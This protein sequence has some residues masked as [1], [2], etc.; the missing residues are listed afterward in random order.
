MTA[1]RD[2]LKAWR[3]A[4]LGM[5]IHWGLYSI[6]AGVWNDDLGADAGIDQA[7]DYAAAGCDYAEHIQ[8][9]RKIPMAEYAR[10]AGRFD[11]VEFDAAEWIRIAEQAGMR[12]IVFTAKHQD[13]FAMYRSHVDPF[14][15]VE[16]TPF[17]RDPLAELAAAVRDRGLG[18]GIYYSHAR[19]HHH[20][21]ANW[22]RYG[23]TWDFPPGSDLQTHIHDEQVLIELPTTA[24]DPDCTVVRIEH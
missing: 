9:R 15:I 11:P 22:N 20:P 24:P 1:T 3:D 13:G 4:K 17:A 23:N 6:P 18:L 8:L 5:F 10:L 2:G 19:D 14:N 7:D 16:A 21:L 12:H